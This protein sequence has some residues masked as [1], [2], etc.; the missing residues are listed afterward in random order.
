MCLA[1]SLTEVVFPIPGGPDTKH[2]FALTFDCAHASIDGD[3]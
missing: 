3:Y 2:P 1:I